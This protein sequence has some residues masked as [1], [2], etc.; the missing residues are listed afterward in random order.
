MMSA[1]AV[2]LSRKERGLL[3]EGTKADIVIVNPTT[4]SDRASFKNPRQF[5]ISVGEAWV[6]GVRVLRNGSHIRASPC[7]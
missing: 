1:V 5:S 6:S 7:R 3:R 4:I 2:R